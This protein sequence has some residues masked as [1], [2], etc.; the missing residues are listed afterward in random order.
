MI[1]RIML[2]E[3]P[4]PDFHVFSFC[5]LPRL[6]LPILGT[7]L[8]QKGYDI[9]ILVPASGRI[10]P[11]ELAQ[12]DLVGISITTS[13]A[14]AGYR[15]ADQVHALAAERGRAIPVVFG[16]VHATFCPEEALAH[17]DFVIR[18]EGEAS[19]PAL[20]EAL[21]HGRGLDGIPGLSYWD[22]PQ[23][24]RN[25]DGPR[26]QDLDGLPS[27]DLS[28]I[29]GFKSPVT[30]IL[31][32][33]GC[34]HNC[35]FCCVTEMMGRQYRFVG[36]ERVLDELRR[37]G[38]RNIFFYDDN[39]AA[40]RGRTKDLLRAM[41]REGLNLEWSAQVR[42]DVADD[43][44]LLSLMRRAG[45]KILYI[46][47][48]SVNQA[49]LNEYHKGLT[50]GAIQR[51]IE[52]I[53]SHGFHIHGMFIFGA[54]NDGPEQ[55]WETVSFARRNGLDTVQFMMLTPLP[56]TPLYERLKQ[57]GRILS[58]DWQ[59]YDGAN[60]VFRPAAMTPYQLQ[61]LTHRAYRKFYSLGL[62]CRYLIRREWLKAGAVFFAQY[63]L[64]KWWWEHRSDLRDLQALEEG[65]GSL[66]PMPAGGGGET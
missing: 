3:P 9:T 31:A 44:E 52:I 50:T 46:G 14:P 4:A 43:G 45:G 10:D 42:S 15:L 55:I 24:R 65:G 28:L 66:A 18:R 6:G 2:V 23:M 21:N 39:F 12:G 48:E 60:V 59:R 54:D 27:P 51:D 37:A 20:I 58:T 26:V 25:E 1:Q 38:T 36:N 17:G 63:T 16:G 53:K 35:T 57:E 41:I 47:F 13:T 19:F 34:P 29:R 62:L 33:R 61:V 8:R 49:A 30:P 11:V 40:N 56:G 32:S 5:N 64:R 7:I 22:G